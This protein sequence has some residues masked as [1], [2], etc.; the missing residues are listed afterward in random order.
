MA[1]G[2]AKIWCKGH[3]TLRKKCKG[4]KMRAIKIVA[5]YAIF[6]LLDRQ[7]HG[8]NVGFFSNLKN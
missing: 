7:T 2:G 1:S 5:E 3:E 4:D 6:V 8:V